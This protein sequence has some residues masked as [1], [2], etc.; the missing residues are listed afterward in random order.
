MKKAK[1]GTTKQKSKLNGSRR[2]GAKARTEAEA[3]AFAEHIEEL[4]RWLATLSEQ[5]H[6]R[7][8]RKITPEELFYINPGWHSI[9][10]WQERMVGAHD[11]RMMK[12]MEAECKQHEKDGRLLIPDR[13]AWLTAGRILF[14]W[15]NDP[16]KQ[17]KARQKPQLNHAQKQNIIRDV[18]I[19][20]SAKKSG[21]V[22]VSD[23]V[24]F[25]IIR[26]YYSFRWVSGKAYFGIE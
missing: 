3:R 16:G 10:V 13:E 22:V 1:T 8:L 7:A 14:A 9:V 12:R 2:N 17:N 25:P 15:L 26:R 4:R 18:L 21:V 23:N 24:D 6:A 19:A 20:V 11:S 5:E